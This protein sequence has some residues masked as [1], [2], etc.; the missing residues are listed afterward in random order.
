MPVP[1]RVW[2]SCIV[3]GYLA[4][5]ADLKRDC[6]QIIEQGRRGELE[7][8]VSAFASV[9]AAYLQG[10]SDSDSEA[11]IREF[12]S[13]DYVIQVAIDISVA[14]IARN[15]IRKYRNSYKIKPPDAAHLAAAIQWHVPIL[16]TTDP[17]LLELD[18]ME[19]NPPV[20][21]RR[22]LYEGPS[23]FPDV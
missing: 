5:Y 8:L 13:R 3:I 9:E 4:G 15:L 21:I 17:D 20:V 6:D 2:D 10:Y 23:R 14:A 18:R 7:I 19:G 22:P 12:F 16:E 1:R 11:K